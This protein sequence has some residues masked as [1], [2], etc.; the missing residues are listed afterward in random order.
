MKPPGRAVTQL[1]D[2]SYFDLLD[3][4]P[5]KIELLD[6]ARSL[7]RICRFNGRTTRHYSVL[8]HS[9]RVRT[10][11]MMTQLRRT[12][13]TL[14]RALLLHDAAEAYTGD[15]IQ[16]M[17]SALRLSGC[18]ALKEIEHR[19][20]RAVEER[21]G[22]PSGVMADP[23]I[24]EADLLALEWERRNVIEPL[25]SL[26]T[27][28]EWP[29]PPEAGRLAVQLMEDREMPGQMPEKDMIARFCD[30]VEFTLL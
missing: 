26:E 29:Q 6:I 18:T 12:S 20:E 4:D 24:K 21:F 9:L 14:E 10:L 27:P 11:G 19:I 1:R 5:A 17:K 7:S 3:P 30:C 15:I 8:E 23:R 13:S 16:P 25:G 2:G 22:L 28:P